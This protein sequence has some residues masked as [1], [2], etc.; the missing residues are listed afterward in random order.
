MEPLVNFNIGGQ[1]H[2]TPLS[3]EKDLDPAVPAAAIAELDKIVFVGE[4][5][6]QVFER[7]GQRLRND[8]QR[9][10]QVSYE[11]SGLR[12]VYEGKE[13]KNDPKGGLYLAAVENVVIKTS[14]RGLSAQFPAGLSERIYNR[15]GIFNFGGVIGLGKRSKKLK[16]KLMAQA[17]GKSKNL[18]GGVRTVAAVHFFKLQGDQIDRLALK[19]AEY[20]REEAERIMH[21]G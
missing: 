10:L 8:L 7:V 21:R 9:E 16:M 4:Q 5:R 18:G 20:F 2:F 13:R 19:F 14:E 3:F 11:R 15:G 6:I 17:E 12:T 1:K